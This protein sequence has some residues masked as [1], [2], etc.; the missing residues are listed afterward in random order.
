MASHWQ[1]NQHAVSAVTGTLVL[2]LLAA[3]MGAVTYVLVSNSGSHQT[4]A[5]PIGIAS[6]PG[7]RSF[8]VINAP[9][10]DESLRYAPN[11]GDVGLRWSGDCQV[12]KINGQPPTN[13]IRVMAGDRLET[14][15]TYGSVMTLVH[16][17]SNTVVAILRVPC[18]GC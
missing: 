7:R 11:P 15:C 16:T 8:S 3:A 2:V 4:Q 1:E 12:T 14:D 5:P 13:L 10:G 9:V 17:D 18:T 6:D